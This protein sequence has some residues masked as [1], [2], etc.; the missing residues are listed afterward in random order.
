MLQKNKEE[1]IPL[2]SSIAKRPPM[3]QPIHQRY[4]S[5]PKTNKEQSTTQN[6]NYYSS[7]PKQ[8]F[9]DQERE[10]ENIQNKK[11][12]IIIRGLQESNIE[13][14][15]KEVIKI[16]RAIGNEDFNRNNISSIARLGD[17]NGRDRPLK[18]ELDSFVTKLKIMR[19][20]K[21]L[22]EEP[23]YYDISIQHD[24]TKFQMIEYKRLVQ[25]SVEDEANDKEGNFKYRVRGPP[26]QWS[27]VKYPKNSHQ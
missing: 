26:G 17:S 18:V 19:N 27:I 25:R 13:N 14:D 8:H 1:E 15:I 2:Y 24:L 23:D 3:K 12:N 22:S 11:N 16:N 20:A 4:T 7:Q 21:Y 9:I 10:R 5:Q 6:R